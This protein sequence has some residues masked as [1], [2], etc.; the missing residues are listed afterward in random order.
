MAYNTNN[1]LGSSDPRD[2]FDNSTNFDQ[3]M[4]SNG[5]T[6]KGRLGQNLYTWAFF[7]RLA[8]S[9]LSQINVIVGT[10]NTAAT[11]AKQQMEQTAAN[12]GADLNNKRYTSYAEMLAD[13]QERDAVVGVVD[14]DPDKSLNGWYQ[15]D[16]T[17]E[18]WIRFNDQPIF[19]SQFDSAVTKVDRQEPSIIPVCVSADGKVAIWID[20]EGNF[21]A[22][23]LQKTAVRG[24]IENY[25]GMKNITP[26]VIGADGKIAVW[27][28]SSGLLSS[29]GISE[30]SLKGFIRRVK[31]SQSNIPIA[32][33]D[34]GK[35][36][37]WIESDGSLGAKAISQ[38]L[39]KGKFAP[40]VAKYDAVAPLSTD[41]R[42]LFK[43]RAKI[44]RL[45]A[46]VPSS[47]IRVGLIS[48]SWGELPAIPRALRNLLAGKFPKCSDGF[49]SAGPTGVID[50]TTTYTY[51][52]DWAMLDGS[53]V[54][55]TGKAAGP[56]GYARVTS[57]ATATAS[58]T[59]DNASAISIYY[60]DLTGSFRYRVDGGD[61][62]TVSTGTIVSVTGLGAGAHNI[63][64]DTV[65]NTGSV[66]LC[67]FYVDGAKDGYQINRMG[68]GSSR[69]KRLLGYAE[70]IGRYVAPM[71]LDLVLVILGTNDQ[72]VVDSRPDV[73]ISALQSVASQVRSVTPNA[74]LVFIVPAQTN[75]SF[76][77]VTPLYKYRD[78][79]YEW[80]INEGHEF[81]NLHDDFGAYAS[82]NALG[83]FAD[84][85]HL[86]DT[87]A[88][89][90]IRSLN[91][92]LFNI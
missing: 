76:S 38:K 32:V 20:D 9:G 80:C 1:P 24:V 49:V 10:V 64:I 71:D 86:N 8:A 12:L 16:N 6:F 85:V 53:E 41:G 51:S 40:R 63:E 47:K 26:I 28:D 67:G 18:N 84:N 46:G 39:L 15:W 69:S 92:K 83:M 50:G 90:M 68:N 14:G 58:L 2:L 7:N 54:D 19:Q 23:G 59:T 30:S 48:D 31:S 29:K 45:E 81:Y 37:L 55:L 88:H 43:L 78:V 62:V 73:F 44:S 87:G 22:R 79:M 34:L 61:W 72:V 3:G 65:G 82:E 56:D 11:A 66:T 33:D 91:R 89:A 17:A 77:V 70:N 25:E 42:T 74:G 75:P 52:S 57:T 4:N 36:A 5:D 27:L 60:G 21:D 35:V 13:P